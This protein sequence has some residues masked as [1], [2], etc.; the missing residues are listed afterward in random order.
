MDSENELSPTLT[1]GQ[2]GLKRSSQLL[3]K[4]VASQ[5]NW[6]LLVGS[7]CEPTLSPIRDRHIENFEVQTPN[8]IIRMRQIKRYIK[9]IYVCNKSS[10]TDIYIAARFKDLQVPHASDHDWGGKQDKQVQT[11]DTEPKPYYA[12]PKNN[13]HTPRVHIELYMKNTLT[14]KPKHL[15]RH[16]PCTRPA[17]HKVQLSRPNLM[18]ALTQTSYAYLITR[19]TDI[20]GPSKAKRSRERSMTARGPSTC[21]VHKVQM[22][23]CHMTQAKYKGHKVG[24][25]GLSTWKYQFS[26][27]H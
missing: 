9:P 24:R 21:K 22:L 27:D 15:Q 23:R 16:T 17:R 20:L 8:H 10:H 26:Y 2:C 18:N 3:K 19:M 13:T 12:K 14:A 11:R 25:S 7:L 5:F 6:T 4:P 1:T